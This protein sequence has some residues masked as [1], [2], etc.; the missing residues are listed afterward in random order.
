MTTTELYLLGGTVICLAIAFTAMVFGI[1]KAASN[2]PY[3]DNKRNEDC[4]EY[5]S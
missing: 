2:C 1:K 3:Q 5:D 4:N